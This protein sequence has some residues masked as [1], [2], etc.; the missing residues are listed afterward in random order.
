MN[1]NPNSIQNPNNNFDSFP[2]SHIILGNNITQVPNS[3]TTNSASQQPLNT[4]LHK[5]QPKTFH[6]T[7][8]KSSSH[9][10]LYFNARSLMNKL[11]LIDTITKSNEHDFIFISETWLQSI[12]KD[13][14]IVDPQYFTMLRTDRTNGRGGGVAAIF[15]NKYAN[16]ITN[17]SEGCLSCG[18]FEI[19]TLDYHESNRKSIRFICLYLPPE[20]SKNV[21]TVRK[22]IN[23]LSS[24]MTQYETYLMGDFNLSGINWNDPKYTATSIISFMFL[25]FLNNNNLVQLI[26]DPTHIHGRTLDLLI[27]SKN[28]INITNTNVREPFSDTNDHNMIEFFIQIKQPQK[29]T[30]NLKYNYHKGDYNKMNNFLSLINWDNVFNTETDLNNIYERVISIIHTAIKAYVPKSKKSVKPSLPRKVKKLLKIKQRTYAALRKNQATKEEYRRA[31]KSYKQAVITNN[32]SY[33]RKISNSSNKNLLYGYM[34]KKLKNKS[35]MPPLR[36]PD[37]VT[38]SEAKQKANLLNEEFQSVYTQDDGNLP[39]LPTPCND[40]IPMDWTVITPKD[41]KRAIKKLK[42]SVSRTPDDVPAIVLK[43]CI[44]NLIVPLAILFNFSLKTK[45][46]P[47]LWKEAIIIPIHKKGLKNSIKNYRPISLTSA[48]CRLME[49]ILQQKLLDHLLKNNLINQNQYGFLPGKS[50]LSQHLDLIDQLTKNHD[51]KLNTEMLYLDFS[52]AFDRVSHQKLLHIL[53]QFKIDPQ[54]Y[55]W[56][57]HYLH[58]RRQR[59]VVED[60]FSAYSSITSGCHKGR[61]SPQHFF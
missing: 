13:S 41:V 58:E 6:K 29:P 37:G 1:L 53:N 18:E 16:R 5:H 4:K 59:T 55:N 61:Y 35:T 23:L 3:A 21:D 40:I 2:S 17:H 48:I 27:T 49:N 22:L 36:S 60:T 8:S 47:T 50:T 32:T 54:I 20:S 28:N 19:L 45:T 24:L 39:V 34:N 7:P 51:N 43:K 30:T 10:V 26:T 33:E 11:Q 38:V 57:K 44:N 46:L 56:L 14:S 52:K 25:S 9:N 31:E 12:Y 15:K 42:M